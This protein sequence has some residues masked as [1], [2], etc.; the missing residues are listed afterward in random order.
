MF[1]KPGNIKLQMTIQL[2]NEICGMSM[3]LWCPSLFWC[4]PYVLEYMQTSIVQFSCRKLGPASKPTLVFH[5]C[6]L[7]KEECLAFSFG[8][9]SLH[10][11]L[12]DGGID[13]RKKLASIPFASWSCLLPLRM[14]FGW[15]VF[16]IL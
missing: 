13:S 11:W 5:T 14:A 1:I 6:L 3:Y 7:F 8:L 9:C 16:N 2:F 10:S 12:P 15:D 4:L